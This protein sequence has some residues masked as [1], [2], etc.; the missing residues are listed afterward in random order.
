MRRCKPPR[1]C[2]HPAV[3]GTELI[4]RVRGLLAERQ[5]GIVC[6]YLFGSLARGEDRAGSDLDLAVLFAAEPPPTLEEGLGLRLA[7]VVEHAIGRPVDLVVLNTAPVDLVH[8]VLRDG[9]LLLDADPSAR[10]RFE[11]AARNAYFDLLPRLRQY[12][13]ASPGSVAVRR[14]SDGPGRTA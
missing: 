10:I 2:Y 3:D 8:R 4:A 7:G 12:R 14:D 11:V 6:A 1:L 5:A 9:I 13:R